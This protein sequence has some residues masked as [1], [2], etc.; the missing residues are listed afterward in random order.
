MTAYDF[1]RLSVLT[2]FEQSASE[3]LLA[4]L[5]RKQF[6]ILEL[7]RAGIVDHATLASAL[8]AQILGR[9]LEPGWDRLADL[10][11]EHLWGLEND[12]VA[13]VW[14]YAHRMLD[15]GLADLIQAADVFVGLSRQMYSDA[16]FVT[17]LLGAGP[18]FP[19][20]PSK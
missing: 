10:L 9:P 5:R 6:A 12:N 13:L 15:G 19:S 18:N 3:P 20:P 7:D 4:W 1:S 17:Y 14:S 11:G 2:L 16:V 8:G